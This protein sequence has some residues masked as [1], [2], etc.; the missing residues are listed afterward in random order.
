LADADLWLREQQDHYEYIATYVDDLLV[1]SRN[2]LAII[3]ELKKDYV[4]KGVGI[5]EYYLGG[6]VE[7]LDE[8]W[9][10]IT[11]ALSAR[12][13]IKNV[14]EKFEQMFSQSSDKPFTFRQFS[15]P[16][17]DAYHPETDDSPLLDPKSS[18][19]FRA[20][21]G[22]AN[23]IITLGRFDIAYAIQAMSRFNMAPRVGHLTAMKRIFGYLKKFDKGRLIIDK[24]FP[25]HSK[26]STNDFDNWTEFYPDATEEL[27]SNMP[28][29][30]GLPVRM[31][32]YVD[33]DHA[34]DTVTRRSI[35]GVL[36]FINN[37]PVKWI[38]KR[39]QTVETSTY[40]SEL[41]AARIA[42]DTIIEF[43]YKLRMLGIP[44]EGPALLLGDNMSVC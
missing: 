32:C 16:M 22:S 11:T 13:Y 40:G 39:Q 42:I 21:V 4:L 38:S 3:E 37:T 6:N 33:A 12:T 20:L 29:P 43:R 9:G 2:P 28:K 7:T 36:L 27:P 23:W 34:H 44:I 15:T 1:F 5:P 31:T 35:T 14:V 10:D 41:V 8:T 30:M 25:D 24:S 18:S 19:Q 17:A 26:Y